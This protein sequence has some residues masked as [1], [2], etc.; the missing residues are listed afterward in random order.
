MGCLSMALLTIALVWVL[1]SA[2]QAEH[3][4]DLHMS[5]A[6]KTRQCKIHG[7]VQVHHHTA[8]AMFTVTQGLPLQFFCGMYMRPWQSNVQPSL[9]LRYICHLMIVACVGADEDIQHDLPVF[10]L[11]PPTQQG[12]NQFVQEV[13]QKMQSASYWSWLAR[14]A[15]GAK[16]KVLGPAWSL[17]YL[18]F[19]QCHVVIP[20]KVSQSYCGS[21]NSQ[22]G[23]KKFCQLK[24]SQDFTRF[25][26]SCPKE[27]FGAYTILHI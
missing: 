27:I 21:T 11:H 16:Q 14:Q 25:Q 12:G 9:L 13:G 1:H 10:P 8:V 15:G 7:I 5:K 18:V 4:T 19:W 22:S 20:Q 6:G 26:D 23:S 2:N 17:V 3:S 24:P